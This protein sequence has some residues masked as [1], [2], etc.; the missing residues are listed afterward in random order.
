[1]TEVTITSKYR[2]ITFST[3]KNIKLNPSQ[4]PKHLDDGYE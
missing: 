4:Q 2:E 3:I 1:M